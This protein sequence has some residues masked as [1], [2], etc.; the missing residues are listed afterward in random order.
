MQS[1]PA[2]SVLMP[3]RNEAAFIERSLGAVLAQD[4]PSDRLEI[5]VADG[6]STD[7]TRE[8]IREVIRKHENVELIEN[9]GKIVAT[10]LNLA[11][12]KARGEIIVRVDGHTIIESDYV[13]ESVA[14]LQASGADNV[15]GRMNAVSD[16][17]FGRAVAAATSSRF[18][19]GGA[20]FHYSDQEEWV[21]TVYLGVWH[22]DVFQRIGAFDEEM[23]RNQDDEFNYRLRASG[24]KILL[25][26]KIQSRYYNRSTLFSLR[27]QYFQY[28][29]WKVRVMQKHPR[30][31]RPRQFVPAM[32]V[33]GLLVLALTSALVTSGW[34]V[35]VGYTSAYFLGNLI[36]SIRAAQRSQ[37]TAVALLPVTFLTMHFAYG[38]GFI[39]GLMKFWSRWQ[40]S[41]AAKTVPR[42]GDVASL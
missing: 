31:M 11:L 26:P 29:F 34:I 23:V 2:V 30:Q 37:W 12:R 21:D 16:R 13:R 15:G 4:Y 17:L 32:F 25:S 35:L 6:M 19:V 39:A 42:A 18:G 14:A 24:G 27:K 28:G 38:L 33:L 22:R 36:A 20:R 9:P 5:I 40:F 8:M 41:P 3:V 10:G 7:G 1:F